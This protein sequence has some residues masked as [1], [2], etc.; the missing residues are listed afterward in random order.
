MSRHL[1]AGRKLGRNTGH[2]K[3]LLRNLVRSVIL[4]ESIRTTTAKAKETRRVVEKLVTKARVGTL[5][6]RRL[7]HRTVRDQA[8]LAKLFETIAPRFKTRPGGYTRLIHLQ[9]RPGDNA[10]MAIL[11]FVEKS[12]KDAEPQGAEKPQ[13]GEAP[14]KKKP[15]KTKAAKG[16]GDQGSSETSEKKPAKQ[17]KAKKEQS[18]EK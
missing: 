2:R 7:V 14:E 17:K 13:G 1:N 11:E 6:A 5:A 12:P 18:E 16:G 3:A 8:A 15:A 10:P 9:N 4:S